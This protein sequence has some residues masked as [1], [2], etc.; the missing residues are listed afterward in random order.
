MNKTLRFRTKITHCIPFMFTSL[1]RNV[2]IYDGAK[3][4]STYNIIIWRSIIMEDNEF[5]QRRTR[6]DGQSYYYF[7]LFIAGKYHSRVPQRKSKKTMTYTW[8]NDTEFETDLWAEQFQLGYSHFIQLREL[9]MLAGGNLSFFT[10]FQK[11]LLSWKFSF[12][13]QVRKLIFR[14]KTSGKF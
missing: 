11:H 9:E 13:K 4:G 1:L 5:E 10:L 12:E 3:Y 2:K 6:N 7:S 8:K 14:G